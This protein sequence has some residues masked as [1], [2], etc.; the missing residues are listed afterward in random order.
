[1]SAPK[2]ERVSTDLLLAELRRRGEDVKVQ[3]ELAG[4]E[5]LIAE[6]KRRVT[7]IVMAYDGPGPEGGT[8]FLDYR[9]KGV[10]NAHVLGLGGCLIR[11]LHDFFD[12]ECEPSAS[13]DD[14][15]DTESAS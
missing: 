14:D 11:R 5:D 9:W 3:L 15:D 8:A 13:A 4:T 7:G 1:M 6:L 12:D 2:F 10:S